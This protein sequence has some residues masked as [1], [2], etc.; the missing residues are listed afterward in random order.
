MRVIHLGSVLLQSSNVG[1]K[2][3]DGLVSSS[4][5]NG[6]AE[7]SGFS[8]GESGSLE[9]VLGET[10]SSSDSDVVSSSLASDNWSKSASGR[11]WGN[12]GGLQQK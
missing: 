1:L 2:T 9:F 4:R 12:S 10:S 5:V 7:L 6:D 8:D 11:S 3:F